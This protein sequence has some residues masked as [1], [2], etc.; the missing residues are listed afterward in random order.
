MDN[1]EG[2]QEA[3]EPG[4]EVQEERV[5]SGECLHFKYKKQFSSTRRFSFLV[6]DLSRGGGIQCVEI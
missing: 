6:I 3:S 5:E 4:G 1:F 2:K